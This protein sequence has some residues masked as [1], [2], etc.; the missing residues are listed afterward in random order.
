MQ[1]SIGPRV[2]VGLNGKQKGK[3]GNK[4]GGIK[5]VYKHSVSVI[6]N[7]GSL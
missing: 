1:I 3:H 2:S 7:K 4:N 6:I 5:A